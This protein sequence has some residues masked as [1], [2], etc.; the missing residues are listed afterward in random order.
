MHVG[1]IWRCSKQNMLMPA[2]WCVLSRQVHLSLVL[3]STWNHYV[4]S[5]IGSP[6]LMQ[7][8]LDSKASL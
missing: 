1:L 8:Q 5:Y 6:D 4:H 2:L 3:A 7:Q